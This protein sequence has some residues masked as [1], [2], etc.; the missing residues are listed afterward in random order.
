L[1]RFKEI[2]KVHPFRIPK[3]SAHHFTH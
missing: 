3:K 2:Q 1:S